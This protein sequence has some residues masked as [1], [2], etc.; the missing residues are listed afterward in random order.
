MGT[1]QPPASCGDW[2]ALYPLIIHAIEQFS[3]TPLFVPIGLTLAILVSIIPVFMVALICLTVVGFILD[4]LVFKP[5]GFLLDRPHIERIIKGVS[6]VVFL[7]GSHFS[8]L[9]Q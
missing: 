6:I 5:V 9:A 8:L 2:L 4:T 1:C 7:I 3:S